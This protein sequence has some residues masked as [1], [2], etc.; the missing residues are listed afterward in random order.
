[1]TI[2]IHSEE[3]KAIGLYGIAGFVGDEGKKDMTPDT[4]LEYAQRALD[5]ADAGTQI[6]CIRLS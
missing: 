6:G 4:L 5:Q 1:M 3:I 2:D